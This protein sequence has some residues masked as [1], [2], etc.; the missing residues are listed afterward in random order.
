MYV[1]RQELAARQSSICQQTNEI[2]W[3]QQK[4]GELQHNLREAAHHIQQLSSEQAK[5]QK[6]LLWCIS[7]LDAQ[8]SNMKK[9][10][11]PLHLHEIGAGAQDATNTEGRMVSMWP[12]NGDPPPCIHI[13]STP[14][15]KNLQL[16]PK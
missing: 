6:S 14:C 1:Q 15:L 8:R 9:P 3:L 10:H 2:H 7:A 13:A 5:L 11:S 12:A 4:I 16:F